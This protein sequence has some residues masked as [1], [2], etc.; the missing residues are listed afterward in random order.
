MIEVPLLSDI[1]NLIGNHFYLKDGSG[2]DFLESFGS[3]EIDAI[4]V[5]KLS[6]LKALFNHNREHTRL[7]FKQSNLPESSSTKSVLVLLNEPDKDVPFLW[8]DVFAKG[9][10]A[11]IVGKSGVNKSTFC[12]QLCL[13]IATK[14][15]T[16]CGLPLTP[17]FGR[18]LYCYSEECEFWLRRYIRK[19]CNG[20]LYENELLENMKVL[21]MEDFETGTDLLSCLRDELTLQSYDVIVFDSYSDF[22]SKFGAKLN[23]ND[24]IRNVK[25]QIGFLNGNGCTVILNHHTSDKSISV[26]SFLGATAFKQI[27]RAQ[28][29]IFEHENERIISCEKNSYGSKFEP[30]VC[31]LSEN[32]LFIPTGKTL[33]RAELVQLVSNSNFTNP[34]PPYRPKIAPCDADAV[35]AVFGTA[36]TLTTMQIIKNLIELYSISDRTA[37]SWIN[38]VYK[39]G[40]VTKVTHGKY[41]MIVQSESAKSNNGLLALTSC[42]L[43]DEGKKLYEYLPELEISGDEHNH[44]YYDDER[45]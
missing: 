45:W 44:P 35:S 37:K 34:K 11:G 42:T 25:S 28:L 24:T 4:T 5:D 26:G 3:G 23:D 21:N 18:T 39:F 27:V 15:S 36:D 9:T 17:T 20:L 43:P 41:A 29:E 22:I 40:L 38:D 10:I 2:F 31:E 6:N 7:P 8:S 33:T 16:F 13:S 12:R 19:N 32:F 14:Q 30:M 1:S